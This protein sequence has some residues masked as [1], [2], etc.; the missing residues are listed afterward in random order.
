MQHLIVD[1]IKLLLEDKGLSPSAFADAIDIQRS[2]MSHILSGRNNPS[3]D[4]IQKILNNFPDINSSW[5]LTGKGKMKQLDLFGAEDER[6]MPE[7]SP[8]IATKQKNEEPIKVE[9]LE[10][11]SFPEQ[12]I[13]AP[14]PEPE[15]RLPPQP[16]KETYTPLPTPQP[17]IASPA[18]QEVAKQLP[19]ADDKQIEKIFVFYTDKTFS[20]YKPE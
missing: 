12:K 11:E 9:K 17:K 5:L 10:T 19:I 16:V 18:K 2:S 8:L 3:L 20:V 14:T 1:R 6:K 13:I 7:P 4:M 15:P